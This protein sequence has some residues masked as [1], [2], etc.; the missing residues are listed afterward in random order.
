[1]LGAL[2][3]TAGI[4]VAFAGALAIGLLVQLGTLPLV[5][6]TSVR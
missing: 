5:R 2:L 3:G 4:G 6:G 1:V